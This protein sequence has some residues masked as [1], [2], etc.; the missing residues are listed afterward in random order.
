MIVISAYK[1]ECT[2]LDT[3][4]SG[5]NSPGCGFQCDEKSIGGINVQRNV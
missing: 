4:D 1:G 3:G 2:V 5:I